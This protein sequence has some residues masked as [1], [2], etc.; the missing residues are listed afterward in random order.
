MD[1]LGQWSGRM[2]GFV[3]HI[4]SGQAA[5]TT[6]DTYRSLQ[7]LHLEALQHGSSPHQPGLGPDSVQHRRLCAVRSALQCR[8]SPL[9]SLTRNLSPLLIRNVRQDNCL[10][11]ITGTRPANPTRPGPTSRIADCSSFQ[12][13]SV[14]PPA[15]TTTVNNGEPTGTSVTAQDTTV[16]P[17]SVPGYASCGANSATR[18]SRYASAC[19]CAGVTQNTQQAPTPTSTVACPPTMPSACASSDGTTTCKTTCDNGLPPICK[20]DGDPCLNTA[21]CVSCHHQCQRSSHR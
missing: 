10:R 8:K 11:A 4:S 12:M 7:A 18:S 6:S 20:A 19:S 17:S 5:C 15:T 14:I 9:I 16:R 13:I 21:E 2:E 3:E 1:G